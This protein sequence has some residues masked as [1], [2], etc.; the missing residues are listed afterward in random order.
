MYWTYPLLFSS[1]GSNHSIANG[2]GGMT[3][4][5][6]NNNDIPD[7]WEPYSIEG[8]AGQAETI[9]DNTYWTDDR[10]APGRQHARDQVDSD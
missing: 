4:L 7:S 8:A 5:D 3:N 9:V 6:T 10:A 2:S 1:P